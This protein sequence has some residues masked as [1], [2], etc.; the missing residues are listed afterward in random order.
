MND[1]EIFRKAASILESEGSV[2]LVTVTEAVGSTPGKPGYKML[3]F[4]GGRETAGTV[5]GGL[6]EARMIEEAARLLGRPSTGVCRVNFGETP[7]DEKGICGGSI[8]F[9]IEAFDQSALPLFQEMISSPG[10]R[11]LVSVMAKDALPRKFLAGPGSSG[12]LAGLAG[13]STEIAPTMDEIVRAGCG[14]AK[15]SSDGVDVFIESMAQLPRVVLFGAGHVASFI[16]RGAASVHFSVT[17]C[18]DRPEYANKERFP[19][20]DGVVVEG[21]GGVFERLRIDAD[22]YLV[23]VTRGHQ[24]DKTVLEQALRT[25]ARYIGMIGSKRKTR[26]ILDDLRKTGFAPETLDRVYAPIGLSLGAVTAEEIALS[27]VA[28]MVKIRRLGHG[29]GTGHMTLANKEKP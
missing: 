17:V 21:F 6:V 9:L 2:A 13:G 22:S 8:E 7:D 3:V 12:A 24:W 23:I 5:G 16:S 11:V 28:E 29:P 4:A 18:D 15:V 25:P 27:V 1:R 20:A 26:A 10:N 14:Q 19:D